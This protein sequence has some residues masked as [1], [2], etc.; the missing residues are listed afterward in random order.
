VNER[1]WASGLIVDCENDTRRKLWTLS[2]TF[3][4]SYGSIFT[5]TKL[6]LI[7][8]A[9]KIKFIALFLKIVLYLSDKESEIGGFPN[10]KI[11]FN[12]KSLD[13]QI[14]NITVRDYTSP[15]LSREY[16]CT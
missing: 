16:F 5:R 4:Y 1:Q 15:P 13:I 8:A 9:N 3:I 6:R 10:L 14:A 2:V 7:C 11:S 12:I